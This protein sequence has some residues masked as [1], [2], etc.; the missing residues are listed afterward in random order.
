VR[1]QVPRGDAQF[2]PAPLGFDAGAEY[3]LPGLPG[4]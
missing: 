4:G 1:R 3:S 2:S